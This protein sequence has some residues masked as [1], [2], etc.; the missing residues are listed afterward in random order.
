MDEIAAL[1][2]AFR[3]DLPYF[4]RAPRAVENGQFPR[5]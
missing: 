1:D 5:R 4:V 2:E 3:A